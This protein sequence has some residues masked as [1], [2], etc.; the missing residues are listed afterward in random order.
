MS[1]ILQ[2]ILPYLQYV[3]V[4]LI[5][6]CRKLKGQTFGMEDKYCTLVLMVTYCFYYG[7]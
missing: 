5:R 3:V 6:K 1:I 7:L 4:A 2:T